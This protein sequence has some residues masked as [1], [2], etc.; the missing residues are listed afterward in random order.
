MNVPHLIEQC[1]R[2]GHACDIDQ[3]TDDGLGMICP[4]CAEVQE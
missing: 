1:D 2:C 3:L 4:S